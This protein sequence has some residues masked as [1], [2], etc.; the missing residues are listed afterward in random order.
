MA[1]R[2][3]PGRFFNVTSAFGPLGA[4]RE[5]SREYPVTRRR[6]KRSQL[7]RARDPR[8]SGTA[9]SA[10]MTVLRLGVAPR[11]GGRR[12][13]IGIAPVSRW[14]DVLGQSPRMRGLGVLR[15]ESSHV[16]SQPG[17]DP[18]PLAEAIS[19]RLVP[20]RNRFRDLFLDEAEAAMFPNWERATAAPVASFRT[21]VGTE[22]DDPR[23]VELVGELSLTSTRFRQ[24]W[25]PPRLRRPPPHRLHHL[26]APAGRT[27]HP[28]PR[29]AAPQRNRR[30]HA[31]HLPPGAK[32]RQRRQARPPR[33]CRPHRRAGPDPVDRAAPRR[34]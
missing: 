16:V 19:P 30:H 34:P 2:L 15:P 7:S 5:A 33:L 9:A 12:Q 27:P 23:V 3:W 6:L 24:L 22:T 20:G 10:A 4:R 29:E 32:N 14:S 11:T 31:R 28:R 18:S 13:P 25:G 26:R 1:I 17:A 8:T 21:T